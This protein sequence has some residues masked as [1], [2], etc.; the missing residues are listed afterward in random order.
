MQRFTREIIA[1]TGLK[2]ARPLQPA[3]LENDHVDE[4]DIEQSKVGARFRLALAMAAPHACY[5]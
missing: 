3:P 1:D 4:T 5:R 2:F